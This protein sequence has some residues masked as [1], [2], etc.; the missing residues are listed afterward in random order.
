[1]ENGVRVHIDHVRNLLFAQ[2]NAINVSA[3]QFSVKRR[4][5]V[6]ELIV[7]LKSKVPRLHKLFECILKHRGMSVTYYDNSDQ[8]KACYLSGDDCM[9]LRQITVNDEFDFI[10]TFLVRSDMVYFIK[11]FYCFAHWEEYVMLQLYD[12]DSK[13]QHKEWEQA[14]IQKYLEIDEVVRA[15]LKP[16]H[17]KTKRF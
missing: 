5:I 14:L 13:C 10:Q 6:T 8:S 1:M 16:L 11:C 7:L 9:H 12:N 2:S 15:M 4:T 17:V 3:T